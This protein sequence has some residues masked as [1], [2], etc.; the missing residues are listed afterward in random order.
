M[1]SKFPFD[2]ILALF[3]V[4]ALWGLY[5]LQG[6]GLEAST[7][8]LWLLVIGIIFI[9]M[10]FIAKISGIKFWFEIPINKTPERSVLMLFFG[11]FTI[12]LLF[13]INRLTNANFYQSYL[14][15][16]LATFNDNIGS[17]TFSALQASTSSFWTFFIAVITAA[18][19]EEI[20]LGW[21]FVKI[22]S[23]IGYG[24]R[25]L[26]KFDLGENYKLWDF[27]F[28]IFIS[29]ISFGMLHLF[30][31]TYIL[32]DGD[33]AWKLIFFAMAFRGLLNLLIYKF[34]N[35]GLMYSIGVHAMHNALI[36]GLSIVGVALSTFP[37]G[38]VLDV[39]LV[40]IFAFA[41][42]SIKK[43]FEEGEIV[44]KDFVTFD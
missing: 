4:F 2:I 11:F 19:I 15:Q 22:G 16:P 7:K 34:G 27:A 8:Y 31:G 6:L 38:I 13:I 24:I 37:L 39:L 41:V 40:L 9:V 20:V 12:L 35:F 14:I 17:T 21:G 23:L 30:N 5:W 29:I 33:I 26:L 25:T 3:V 44:A 10:A 28:A 43:L 32:L 18:V 1:E 36:L 42:M